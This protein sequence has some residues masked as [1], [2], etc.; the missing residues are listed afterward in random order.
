M[1]A[2]GINNGQK[3]RNRYNTLSKENKKP[4]ANA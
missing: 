3:V 4:V 2:K 1:T